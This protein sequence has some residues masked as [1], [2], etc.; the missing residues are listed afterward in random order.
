MIDSVYFNNKNH[1]IYGIDNLSRNG[2]KYNLEKLQ[3]LKK[4]KFFKIDVT[5][6]KKLD[7]FFKKNKFDV[8]FHLAAQVSLID[9]VYNP[10]F[11][12]NENFI[13]TF[14]LLECLRM[15]NK[16]AK[17]VYSSTNKVFGDLKELKILKN[18]KNFRFKDLK[19][20]INEDYPI[21]FCGPYG[22]SKGSAESYVVDYSKVYGLKTY[23]LRKSCIY[24]T[25]QF[26]MEAQGW[27]SWLIIASLLKKQIYVYGDGNQARDLL[28]VDDLAKLYEK[29]AKN[30]YKK[31]N[32]ILNAGGGEKN[33]LS[34]NQILNYL[35]ENLILDKKIK[36][37]KIRPADQKLYY[38]DITKAKK[39]FKWYPKI[40]A[41][42]GVNKMMQFYLKNNNLLKNIYKK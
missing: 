33:I 18:N 14:N 29:I 35:T 17:F 15:Y 40:K 2:S 12:M 3:K 27:V 26:G 39:V 5:D 22:C 1:T 24:G 31:E 32:C 19:K 28:H 10:R 6:K 20:G 16:R 36:Y 30:K 23:S 9:S 11:D 34:V 25:N 37:S 4:F 8:I 21:K 7:Y 42:S 13:G 41:W 38:T